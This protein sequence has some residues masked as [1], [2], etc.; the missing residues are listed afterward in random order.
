MIHN[1]NSSK[2]LECLLKI[3]FWL[4][5]ING[6]NLTSH[7]WSYILLVIQIIFLSVITVN[8]FLVALANVYNRDRISL[9]ITIS[10]TSLNIG[11]R[12]I[13]LFVSKNKVN[14]SHEWILSILSPASTNASL[15]QI[16][17]LREQIFNKCGK[18]SLIIVK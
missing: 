15:P 7:V 3:L 14:L 5:R 1:N 12:L 16:H 18:Q 2:Y 6:L 8:C 4:L 13:I 10:I 17:R 9:C 11:I